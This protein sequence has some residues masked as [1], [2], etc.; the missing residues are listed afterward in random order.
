MPLWANLDGK[1]ARLMNV[2]AP[3]PA[4]NVGGKADLALPVTPVSIPVIA[5]ATSW[6]GIELSPGALGSTE[7]STCLGGE[8]RSDVLVQQLGLRSAVATTSQSGATL[9]R[10]NPERSENR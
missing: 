6:P 8:R 3:L 1:P 5:I 2:G 10:L 7:T 9:C 4:T